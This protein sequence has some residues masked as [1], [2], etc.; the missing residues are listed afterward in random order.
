MCCSKSGREVSPTF[1][2]SL[3][4]P[5]VPAS[6]VDLRR[7]T[8]RQTSSF[9]SSIRHH[10]RPWSSNP[11]HCLDAAAG[12]PTPPMS[13]PFPSG[14]Q[15]P[16]SSHHLFP[17]DMAYLPVPAVR[18][19]LASP[20]LGSGPLDDI[21]GGMMRITPADVPVSRFPLMHTAFGRFPRE[22]ACVDVPMSCN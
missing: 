14:I 6:A 21:M 1:T 20:L 7:S 22:T 9:I 17:S 10:P 4:L 8:S 2:H 11:K 5:F 13:P 12:L 3:P 15:S 16:P 19:D 18:R